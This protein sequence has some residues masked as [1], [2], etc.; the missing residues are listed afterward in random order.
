MWL[1]VYSDE[2]DEGSEVRR[3]HGDP[4]GDPPAVERRRRSAE[5]E[6]DPQR[7]DDDGSSPESVD[8]AQRRLAGAIADGTSPAGDDGEREHGGEE[9]HD[10]LRVATVEPEDARAAD[11]EHGDRTDLPRLVRR[12]EGVEHDGRVEQDDEAVQR[13]V[14]DDLDVCLGGLAQQEVLRQA[15]DAEQDPEDGRQ[16]DAGHCQAQGVEQALEQGVADR[17]GLAEV[18]AEDREASRLVE[19]VEA[20]RE[21]LSVAVDLD[22]VVEPGDHG[23]DGGEHRQLER[24]GEDADVAVERRAPRGV[25]ATLAVGVERRGG[26]HGSVH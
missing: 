18:A 25:E 23:D 4:S 6:E 15:G 24:P 3:R 13:D 1:D 7:D 11:V 2:G 20:R 17:L 26:S 9:D 22:V 5:P 8:A 14:A 19:V 12:G 10:E 16:H 21:V